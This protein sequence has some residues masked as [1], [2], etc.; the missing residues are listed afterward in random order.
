VGICVTL[1]AAFSIAQIAL[2]GPRSTVSSTMT[3]VPT[4]ALLVPL[5]W[6]MACAVI[7]VSYARRPVPRHVATT[8]GMEE[9]VPPD[10]AA[11]STV[12]VN[13]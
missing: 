7:V 11:A 5:V 8:E 3:V 6:L 12:S 10:G 13:Q 9:A 4:T 2:P 1:A